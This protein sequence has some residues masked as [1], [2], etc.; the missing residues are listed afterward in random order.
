VEVELIDLFPT[1]HPLLDK[2][3]DFSEQAREMALTLN[4][5]VKNSLGSGD[6]LLRIHGYLFV[7]DASNKN[8]FDTLACLIETIKEI[9]KSE[10]RGKKIMLYSPKKLVLGNKK[11]LKRRKQVLEKNDLMKLEG[12][13]YREASALTNQGVMESIKI[14]LAD[15][16]SCNI[17]HKEFFDLEKRKNR[18][19][20]ELKEIE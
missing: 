13:R 16:H 3:P 17:L 18:D 15:I 4:D 7:F 6:P 10:R 14:L 12:M 8:T 5:V 2:D 19:K 11:D 9:E 20:E 1:D